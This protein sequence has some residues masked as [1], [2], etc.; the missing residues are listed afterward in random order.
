[1]SHWQMDVL[2][3]VGFFPMARRKEGGKG[4]GKLIYS[5]KVKFAGYYRRHYFEG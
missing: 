5:N 2:Q 3:L 1:M 4:N